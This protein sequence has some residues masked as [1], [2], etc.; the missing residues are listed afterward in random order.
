MIQSGRDSAHG[1]EGVMF[2][3][4]EEESIQLNFERCPWKMPFQ[5]DREWETE[6]FTCLYSYK[7][8][9]T[10]LREEGRVFKT[11]YY[12]VV[13][14]LIFCGVCVYVSVS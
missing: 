4:I 3:F 10:A 5:V 14:A 6:Y 8:D 1:G 7:H 13:Q 12:N 11:P 2:C 9:S